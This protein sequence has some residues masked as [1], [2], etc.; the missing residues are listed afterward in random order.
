[1]YSLQLMSI[2]RIFF[3][4]SSGI[5]TVMIAIHVLFVTHAYM[6]F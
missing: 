5:L 1:M 4:S 2:S 3:F 6:F